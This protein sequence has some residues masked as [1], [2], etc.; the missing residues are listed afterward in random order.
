MAQN[1]GRCAGGR[2]TQMVANAGKSNWR[3][4]PVVAQRP[5]RIENLFP[6]RGTKTCTYT[7]LHAHEHTPTPTPTH[8]HPHRDPRKCMSLRIDFNHFSKDLG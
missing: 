6:G 7:R 5:L 4:D 3:L 1:R 8:A 2:C